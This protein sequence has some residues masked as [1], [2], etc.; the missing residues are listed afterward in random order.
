VGYELKI[1]LFQLPPGIVALIGLF[2]T[3]SARRRL[4]RQASGLAV[5][6]CAVLAA[7]SGA[8]A[9]WSVYLPRAVRA[10][11]PIDWLGLNYS[12][13]IDLINTALALGYTV[14][15]ML[16]LAAAFAGRRPPHRPAPDTPHPPGGAPRSE[17]R[18]MASAA[19]S[20]A[21]G[22]TPPAQSQ[23]SD[24]SVMS[25]VWSI[26]P[27]TF[28]DDR[29]DEPRHRDPRYPDEPRYR[30]EPGRDR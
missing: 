25:G 5:A 8:S 20:T 9:A 13:W 22:W 14:S 11:A 3:L 28:R 1:L 16:L 24:W 19:P 12:V 4:G 23:Q 27:D 29:R 26:P 30:D 7:T 17:E 21:G 15:F 18:S 10:N 6:G 2:S